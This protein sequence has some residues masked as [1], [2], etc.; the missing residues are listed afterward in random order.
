MDLGYFLMPMHPPG[1]PVTKWL[2]GDLQQIVA[3][4]R[5]G[6]DEAWFGE[7]YTNEWES[8]TSPDLFIANALARTENIRLGT[9]VTSLSY[10]QPVQLAS[11][12]ALLDHLAKGRF[13]WGI[14]NGALPTDGAMF[15]VDFSKREQRAGSRAVLDAVLNLWNNP[16]PGVYETEF[17]KFT[18]PE[19]DDVTGTRYHMKPYTQPHPPIAAAGSGPKSDM[20]GYAG[21]NGWIPMSVNFVIPWTVKKQ[22]EVYE[23]AAVENGIVPDRRLWRVNREVVVARTDAEARELAKSGALARDWMTYLIPL[24]RRL[25]EMINVKIDPDMPDDLIDIDYFIDNIWLVGSPET[26]TQKVK[27]LYEYTGGFGVLSVAGHD[28][29]DAGQSEESMR[30]LAEEVRPNLPTPA[31]PEEQVMPVGAGQQS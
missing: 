26:V 12:I 10:H 11:R 20:L 25:G 5:L 21:A 29:D 1:T 23:A 16:E 6:F 4:D 15:D 27:D 22:W 2:D 28:W 30:L 9:G 14:G 3:L 19:P 17:F 31:A 13:M 8:L 24:F 18:V 7:H